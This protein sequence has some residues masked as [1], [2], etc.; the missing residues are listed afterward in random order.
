MLIFAIDDERKL[1]QYLHAAIAEAAP[2]A[3]IRDFLLGQP[4]LDAIREERLRPDG[5]L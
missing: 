2:E 1:L 4:A 5:V 3:E